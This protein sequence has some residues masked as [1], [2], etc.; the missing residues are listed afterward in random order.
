[1]R[2]SVVFLH[3]VCFLLV[4]LFV[5]ADTKKPLPDPSHLSLG[6]V[7]AAIYE[8]ASRSWLHTKHADLVMP[9]A[10][11]SKL[12]TAMVIID[13][14]QALDEYLVIPKIRSKSGKSAYSRLRVGSQLKRKD[15]LLISLMSSEN[16]ATYTL[17]HYYPGGM[18][19]FLKAM[20]KKARS[21]GM[22][23]TRFDDA[24]GLSTGN[25]STARDVVRMVLAARDYPL[26]RDY[27]TTVQHTARFRK[28]NYVLG[29]ANTNRLV[30][31]ANWDIH[32]SK[33]G[34]LNEA[35]RCLAL[36]TRIEGRDLVVVLLDSFGKQTHIGDAGRIRRWMQTG[37]SGTLASAA[38]R[39][40]S[41][42]LRELG[43]KPG[44]GS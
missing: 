20:N 14:G 4:S 23:H 11:L 43:V 40:Q 38:V 42:K 10:S 19:T 36:F 16:L 17:A 18:E 13:A 9:I 41:Q 27:S 5:Q 21:L 39:Y 7:S 28:P 1:M 29:Y 26:I 22:M 31:N 15:L 8:P 44:A 34:F 24:A 30:Q 12:M 6:S 32:L 3:F 35:G 33:T 37:S 2:R 25:V